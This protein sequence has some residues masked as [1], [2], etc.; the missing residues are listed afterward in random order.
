MRENIE[1]CI[2][3]IEKFQILK[4]S[5]WTLQGEII[6]N[7]FFLAKEHME[8]FSNRNNGVSVRQIKTRIM[9]LKKSRRKKRKI[10]GKEMGIEL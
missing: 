7:C 10:N 4:E 1:K 9:N 6:C 2:T 5:M 8:L 3:M